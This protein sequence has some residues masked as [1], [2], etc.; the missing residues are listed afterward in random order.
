MSEKVDLNAVVLETPLLKSIVHK[1]MSALINQGGNPDW[2]TFTKTDSWV[3]HMKPAMTEESQLRYELHWRICYKS[4]PIQEALMKHPPTCNLEHVALAG[5]AMVYIWR[6]LC[7]DR[8]A[9]EALQ[10]P[11]SPYGLEQLQLPEIRLRVAGLFAEA[12]R[13]KVIRL[14]GKKGTGTLGDELPVVVMTRPA[15]DVDLKDYERL[16]NEGMCPHI[17]MRWADTDELE[18][19]ETPDAMQPGVII[20]SEGG[21]DMYQ[22]QPNGSLVNITKHPEKRRRDLP[23]DPDY[24]DPESL[25]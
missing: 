11:L 21:D 5:H 6:E 3:K 25:N 20:G 13:I 15:G 9:F 23:G 1:Q 24:V 4:G 22:R 8:P 16:M 10:P 7:E 14:P 2:L 17:E 19:E 18:T 12:R